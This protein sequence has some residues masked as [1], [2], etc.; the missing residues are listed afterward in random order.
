MLEAKVESGHTGPFSC[1]T[2]YAP[3]TVN[4]PASVGQ[5]TAQLTIDRARRASAAK[6]VPILESTSALGTLADV[7][8]LATRVDHLL[9]NGDLEP[10]IGGH[11]SKL[12][13]L[14]RAAL[15]ANRFGQVR[16]Q[17]RSAAA[18][19]LVLA[20]LSFGSILLPLSTL[21]TSDACPRWPLLSIFAVGLLTLIGFILTQIVRLRGY[22]RVRMRP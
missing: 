18:I 16:L 15:S 17:W 8:D 4:E 2:I 11:A 5:P 6:L 21:S 19:W 9:K 1:P 14:A 3:F 7:A 10:E 22:L 13:D 12:H 20:I